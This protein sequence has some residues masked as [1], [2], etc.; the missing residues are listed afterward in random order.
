LLLLYP[1]VSG[2]AHQKFHCSG[3]ISFIVET[4]LGDNPHYFFIGKPVPDPIAANNYKPLFAENWLA[5]LRWGLRASKNLYF[6]LF[7]YTYI[8]CHHISY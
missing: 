6:R 3:C 7:Y 2:C 5:V 1:P 8:L 4:L